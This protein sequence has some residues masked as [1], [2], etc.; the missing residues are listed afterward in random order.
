MRAAGFAVGGGGGAQARPAKDGDRMERAAARN[1]AETETRIE[2]EHALRAV[3]LD[4][5]AAQ[6]A[7]QAAR[8]LREEADRM[9]AD[10]KRVNQ[11]ARQA[12]KE[13]ER[14]MAK[15]KASREAARRLSA[16][17]RTR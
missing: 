14:S 5:E 7:E 4:E 17:P 1:A 9:A 11:K 15:A 13:V 6:Q 2:L 12:A 8:R 3:K 10:A 16:G